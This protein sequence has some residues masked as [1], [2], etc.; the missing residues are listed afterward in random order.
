MDELSRVRLYGLRA[1]YLFV[2]VGLILMIWPLLLNQPDDLEHMRGVV[3]CMLAAVSLLALAGLLQPVRVLPGLLFEFTWKVI[4]LVGVGMPRR[5]TASFTAAY[6][7]TWVECLIGVAL[8]LIAI[9]WAYVWRNY[10]PFA[11]TRPAKTV[12]PAA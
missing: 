4:W 7:E 5:G 1:M 3:W 10:M 12:L 2:G 11:R 6:Q 9:P 8:L